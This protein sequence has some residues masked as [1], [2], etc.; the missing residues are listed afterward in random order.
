MFRSILS[1]TRE[2]PPAG[3]LLNSCNHV[4]VRL[5][6]KTIGGSGQISLGKEFAGRTVTV[7]ELEPGVWMIKTAQVIPDNELWLHTPEVR[8]SVDRALADAQKT[9][10][11][12]A[13][14]AGLSRR[15][16]RGK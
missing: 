4:I 6:V 14:L 16:R 1:P 2:D 3:S 11:S 13:N 10:R 9:K 8:A 15:V 7:E 12:E 5:E